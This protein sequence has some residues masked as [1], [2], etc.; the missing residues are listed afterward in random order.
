MYAWLDASSGS[1]AGGWSA[2]PAAVTD[3]TGCA[4]LTADGYL[5]CPL[6][7]SIGV[8]GAHCD[9][10]PIES[11]PLTLTGAAN[12]AGYAPAAHAPRTVCAWDDAGTYTAGSSIP[13]GAL[14]GLGSPAGQ[15]CAFDV[16]SGSEEATS[17][18]YPARWALHPII[19]LQP[20][21]EITTQGCAW[22][23]AGK[24]DLPLIEGYLLVVGEDFPAGET[25]T[26]CGVKLW[27]QAA[28]DTAGWVASLADRS[29]ED[30]PAGSHS[31]S[32]GD[33]ISADCAA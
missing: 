20:G 25:T 29:G 15:G 26:Q 30:L 31:F 1:P 27:R 11:R 18:D 12:P 7:E 10:L 5:A 6:L 21:D 32:A 23:P 17:G 3:Y 19:Y 22:V 8:Q 4:Y 24:A 2:Q 14:R 16:R 13:A 28:A 9:M 33:A